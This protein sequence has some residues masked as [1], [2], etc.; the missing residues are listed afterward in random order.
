MTTKDFII[1]LFFRIEKELKNVEKHL[2]VKLHP[3]EVITIAFLC[4]LRGVENR[5]FYR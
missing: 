3:T 2:Q 1:E 5:A 4:A